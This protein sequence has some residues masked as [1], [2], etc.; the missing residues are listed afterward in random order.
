MRGLNGLQGPIGDRGEK[1]NSGLCEVEKCVT[2]DIKPTNIDSATNSNNDL[3]DVIFDENNKTAHNDDKPKIN[4]IESSKPKQDKSSISQTSSDYDIMN[5]EEFPA[6]KSEYWKD[7]IVPKVQLLHS[8]DDQADPEG[9][10]TFSESF[11]LPE[12]Y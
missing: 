1:G 2:K 9:S 3:I 10:G 7:V 12:I 8:G 4:V 6:Y 11:H 5:S